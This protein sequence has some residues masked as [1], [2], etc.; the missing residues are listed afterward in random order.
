M[1]LLH[2]EFYTTRRPVF[3]RQD[4]DELNRLTNI[5][6]AYDIALERL[7]SDLDLATA[8]HDG[9]IHC[10]ND[11][12]L[13]FVF[14][15]SIEELGYVYSVEGVFQSMWEGIK[16][17]FNTIIEKIKQFF[18]W[19]ARLF[20][21]CKSEADK[22]N[23][24]IKEL[25]Q[26][27]DAYGKAKT[28]TQ[29]AILNKITEYRN[30]GIKKTEESSGESLFD[31]DVWSLMDKGKKNKGGNHGNNQPKNPNPPSPNQN[32]N[33]DQNQQQQNNNNNQQQQPAQPVSAPNAESAAGPA[34]TEYLSD[35]VIV[36]NT[37]GSL[38][39]KAAA[40]EPALGKFVQGLQQITSLSNDTM[41]NIQSG[42]TE[43]G[44]DL[45]KV[46][47][48][49]MQVRAQFNQ[50]QAPADSKSFVEAGNYD[51]LNTN[52]GNYEQA[53]QKL[54]EGTKL[55]ASQ[56]ERIS[57]LTPAAGQEALFY[58]KEDGETQPPPNPPNTNNTENNQQAN[59]NQ[60][61]NQEDKVNSQTAK[62]ILKALKTTASEVQGVMK[63]I[64]RIEND[65]A[66]TRSNFNKMMGSVVKIINE[67][68]KSESNAAS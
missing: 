6:I 14:K 32:Q 23:Q 21:F 50:K 57:K 15:D 64:V 52:I 12:G 10:P 35:L 60:P 9:M 51:T 26:S 55:L 61:N 65:C 8:L 13:S 68:L 22:S 53:A 63:D 47:D 11:K 33:N 45:K 4:K 2:T 67:G 66:N 3:T 5:L 1:A 48:E 43:G 34:S 56:L 38:K 30:G 40:V 39:D 44:T 58:S 28:E 19:V 18:L 59:P 29:T 24:I 25:K 16:K 31:A 49:Y 37:V 42:A 41:G 20:G 46:A 54:S 27:L 36:A 62:Q 17:V 7:Q